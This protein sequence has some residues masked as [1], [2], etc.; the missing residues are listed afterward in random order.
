MK[1]LRFL[2]LV[3]VALLM[4]TSFAHVLELPAKMQYDGPLYVTLQKSLYVTWGPPNVGGFLEPAAIL[5]VAALAFLNRK[6]R[7]LP[8]TTG[9]LG[10]LLLAFPVVFFLFV[11]PANAAFRLAAPEA[12]PQGWERFRETWEYGHATRFVLHLTAFSLL[13]LS[14]LRPSV[15]NPASHPPPERL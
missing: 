6:R 14:V 3:L 8:L 12:L 10:A 13:A 9:A 4:G 15:P 1:P 2:T 5:A 7:G 11:A